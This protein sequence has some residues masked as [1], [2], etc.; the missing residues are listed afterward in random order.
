LL[1]LIAIAGTVTPFV[2]AQEENSE[3]ITRIEA[4]FVAARQIKVINRIADLPE[5]V[6]ERF[7]SNPIA[8]FWDRMAEW[9]EVW[10]S[11][12]VMGDEEDIYQHVFSGLSETV[13]IVLYREGGITGAYSILLIAERGVPGACRYHL[14]D[15]VP[16]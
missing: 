5:D 15:W 12:D 10:N 14:D 16:D 11:L 1:T 4:A 8:P 7:D 3:E 6:L 9:G 2:K 13:A